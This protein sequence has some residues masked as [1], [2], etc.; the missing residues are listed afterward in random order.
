MPSRSRQRYQTFLSEGVDRLG[1]EPDPRLFQ[2][3]VSSRELD[4]NVCAAIGSVRKR[5]DFYPTE[6]L[7]HGTMHPEILPK[8]PGGPIRVPCMLLSDLID[9]YG[10]D[11]AVIDFLKIDV[12]GGE[13][14][15]IA[16]GDWERHRPRVLIIEAVDRTGRPNF[17]KYEALLAEKK[18][19]FGL[20]DGLNRFYCRQEDVDELLPLF[21]A[22]ANIFDDFRP[23]RE[24]DATARAAAVEAERAAQLMAKD[25]RLHELDTEL[26]VSGPSRSG[27]DL[28]SIKPK[29]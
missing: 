7:G 22:P 1:V 17:E 2:A 28:N 18:Y 19:V 5:M 27:S 23:I 12:E 8:K 4:I 24:A 9:I 20:F 11:Y 26:D 13:Y 25:A 3:F 29:H 16:S 10:S 21:S 14:D 15:V 6:V